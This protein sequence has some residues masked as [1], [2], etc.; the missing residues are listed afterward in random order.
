MKRLSL[1]LLSAWMTLGLFAQS[2]SPN[3]EGTWT[4]EHATTIIDFQLKVDGSVFQ[5]TASTHNPSFTIAAIVDGQYRGKATNVIRNDASGMAIGS[6]FSMTVYGIT[7][8]T[9][10]QNTLANKEITLHLYD[11]ENKLEYILPQTFTFDGEHHGTLEALEEVSYTTVTSIAPFAIKTYPGH[12]FTIV[13]P[14]LNHNGTRITDGTKL[15]F[16]EWYLD[17]DLTGYTID[18]KTGKVSISTDAEVGTVKYGVRAGSL[19][20]YGYLN[21]YNSVQEIAILQNPADVLTGTTIDEA[22]TEGK[23]FDILPNTAVQTFTYELSNPDIVGEDNTLQLGETEVTITSRD[24]TE[25]SATFTLRV[26][27][28]AA[29]ISVSEDIIYMPNTT[30]DVYAFLKPYITINPETAKQDFELHLSIVTSSRWTTSASSLSL[31]PAN[32]R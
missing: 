23:F 29:E 9:T 27:D 28:N 11:A 6:Y 21:V 5:H 16:D 31:A 13:Y 19:D 24:N 7:D 18:S 1:L 3:D 30:E 8:P 10:K 2:W 22:L 32:L 15:V 20:G 26:F 14:A 12:A 17:T 25:V 4:Q